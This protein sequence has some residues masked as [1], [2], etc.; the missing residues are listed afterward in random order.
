MAKKIH[1]TYKTKVRRMQID[2]LGESEEDESSLSDSSTELLPNYKRKIQIGPNHQAVCFDEARVNEVADLKTAQPNLKQVWDPNILSP[3]V[4][5]NYLIVA[6]SYYK[7][8]YNLKEEDTLLQLLSSFN[9]TVADSLNCLKNNTDE[10]R[11]NLHKIGFV[12]TP[13]LCK[14][15]RPLRRRS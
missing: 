12:R 8:N 2:Y 13:E 3:S 10:S 6:E 11:E 5:T 7:A 1:K 9:Y 15:S 4:V 14:V